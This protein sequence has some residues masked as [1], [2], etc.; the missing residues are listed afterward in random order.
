MDQDGQPIGQVI[1]PPDY[2]LIRPISLPDDGKMPDA[3]AG[4]S[5]SAEYD[6]YFRL[7]RESPELTTWSQSCVEVQR[8]VLE[9]LNATKLSDQE[10]CDMLTGFLVI[11]HSTLESWLSLHCAAEAGQ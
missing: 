1:T 4:S 9:D 10:R 11:M 8:R 5:T 3:T 2:G 7:V 6:R